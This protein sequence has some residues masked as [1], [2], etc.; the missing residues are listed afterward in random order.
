MV[1]DGLTFAELR[2]RDA[3]LYEVVTSSRASADGASPSYVD[4]T[5]DMGHLN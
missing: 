4:A 2:A 5:L 3:E 1:A